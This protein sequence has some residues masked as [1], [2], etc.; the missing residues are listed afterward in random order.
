MGT[1]SEALRQEIASIR[2]FNGVSGYNMAFNES[3]EMIKGIYVYELKDG[4][5][6]RVDQ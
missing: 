3:K 1:D 4:D 6:V 2:E 5:F